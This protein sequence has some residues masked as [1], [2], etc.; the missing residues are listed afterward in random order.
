MAKDDPAGQQA[1]LTTA[2]QPLFGIHYAFQLSFFLLAPCSTLLM[3]IAE[4][5][6]LRYSTTFSSN[7]TTNFST[8]R[9]KLRYASEN[10]RIEENVFIVL[11][12]TGIIDGGGMLSRQR[13]YVLIQRGDRFVRRWRGIWIRQRVAYYR[14]LY[15][16]SPRRDFRARCHTDCIISY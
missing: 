14:R 4:I 2:E 12:V 1:S 10:Y 8:R 6:A 13:R 15:T 11:I 16:S 3:S 9:D 7:L 5:T